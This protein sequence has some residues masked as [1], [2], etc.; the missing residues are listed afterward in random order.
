MPLFRGNALAS[1]V[2]PPSAPV[3]PSCCAGA[4]RPRLAAQV[5]A[6]H[7]TFT[8]SS[9]GCAF[10]SHATPRPTRYATDLKFVL[11]PKSSAVDMSVQAPLRRRRLRRLQVRER[12]RALHQP[13]PAARRPRHAG[14]R[15]RRGRGRPRTSEDCPGPLTTTPPAQRRRGPSEIVMHALQRFEGYYANDKGRRRPQPQRLGTG[16]ATSPPGRGRC[17]PLRRPQRRLGCGR[18]RELRGGA[19]RRI[20]P[21]ARGHQRGPCSASP[22]TAPSTTRSWPC[23]GSTPGPPAPS[24]RPPSTPSLAEQRPPLRHQWS[25]ATCG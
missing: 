4:S 22:T 14:A 12:H 17:L 2:F 16:Q 9:A 20:H 19:R 21:A 1:M 24:T 3:P 25:P 8:A 5:R 10:P 6:E 11:A 15:H 13:Q 7:A 23:S 18:Q